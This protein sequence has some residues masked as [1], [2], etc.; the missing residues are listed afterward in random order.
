MIDF[1]KLHEKF[2]APKL[3]QQGN[4]NKDEATVLDK[5]RMDSAK[6]ALIRE[7]EQEIQSD[8]EIQ[9][10]SS[11]S[12]LKTYSKKEKEELLLQE[13]EVLAMEDNTTVAK[14]TSDN[15]VSAVNGADDWDFLQSI[16]EQTGDFEARELFERGVLRECVSIEAVV[17]RVVKVEQ[18]DVLAYMYGYSKRCRNMLGESAVDLLV[19]GP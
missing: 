18:S 9:N 13:A 1:A 3:A 8:F 10:F 11:S 16:L 4:Q 19:N 12:E 7:D 14:T 2:L 17:D 6:S 15:T 5:T